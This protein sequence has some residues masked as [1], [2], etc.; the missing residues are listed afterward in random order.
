MLRGSV[1]IRDAVP[2]DADALLAIWSDFTTDGSLAVRP[3]PLRHE[4]G[5]AVGRTAA[6]SDERLL[7]AELDGTVV[8]MLHLRRA[9][10]SPIHVEDSVRMSNLHVLSSFRRR[11]VGRQL[12]EKAAEWA[13]EKATEHLAAHVAAGARDT[14]RFLAR[15]GL[16][17]VAVVR[18]TS[19]KSLRAKLTLRDGGMAAS[20]NL[21]VARRRM[22]RRAARAAG[23]LVATRAQ[24]GSSEPAGT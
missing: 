13:D 7:V 1:Q 24:C 18:A 22:R 2:E 19:V 14:N 21:L 12:I 10:L 8:G 15:L 17:Q 3:L 11:G 23:D 6:D 9:P 16:T 4:V 20:S 5:A